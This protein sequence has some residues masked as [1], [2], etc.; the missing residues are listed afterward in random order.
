M[1][2]DYTYNVKLLRKI[3]LLFICYLFGANISAQ[4][5][6]E[7]N[8]NGWGEGLGA[9]KPVICDIDGNGLNDLLVGNKNG[10]ILHFEQ[11]VVGDTSF[12]IISN[13][14]NGIEMVNFIAPTITDIDGDGLLD[15]IVG[16]HDGKLVHYEQT[17]NQSLDFALITNFFNNIDIGEEATPVFIDV[18]NDSCLDLFI[19]EYQG[20]VNHYEQNEPYSSVFNFVTHSFNNIDIGER[21]APAFTDLN[22]DGRLDLFIGE[23]N[24][25]INHYSQQ[26]ENSY[27]FNYENDFDY[28]N[29]DA[30]TAPIFTD[31][32]SD[33]FIDMLIGDASGNIKLYEQSGNP[34]SEIFYEASTFFNEIDVGEFAAPI[35]Y[36][37][38][39]DGFLDMIIGKGDGRLNH[40]V[41][42]ANDPDVFYLVN[43]FFN[44][45][46]V[47]AMSAPCLFDIDN[48]N[49]LDL[50]IGSFDYGSGSIWHYEQLNE[51][52]L[53]F[54]L[55]T[56]NFINTTV[57]LASPFIIDVDNNDLLDL[58]IGNSFSF[59]IIHA[60]QTEENTY[61]FSIVTDH[62]EDII[63]S[64]FPKPNFSDFDDDG[65]LELLIGDDTG[66]IYLYE[67]I[68][69]D[70][71]GFEI[72]T[73]NFL[74]LLSD[75]K[76]EQGG[77][78]S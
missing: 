75:K 3:L 16:K 1:K 17:N 7:V 68:S 55:V 61:N 60:K 28:M 46:D 27:T 54:T 15:L 26:E 21:S 14:F 47:G 52:S 30:G 78:I 51:N 34:N 38:D 42:S 69:A 44:E 37:I 45:I 35:V 56:E 12:Y 33:G 77:N 13:D 62:F 43:S 5:Y 65:V 29:F 8:D 70:T 71:T 22:Y 66:T 11:G 25:K 20:N 58:F 64:A 31:L 67:Q 40:Y 24:G 2:N 39:S 57:S 36:D 4:H 41:Q 49:L 50:I 48:D 9:A 59:R 72:I 73:P 76:N 23:E 53:V 32:D 6:I 18:D 74:T 19:G 10:K 63:V